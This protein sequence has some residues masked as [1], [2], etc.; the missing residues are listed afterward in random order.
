MKG[1]I[2]VPTFYKA[3]HNNPTGQS[4]RS[5]VLLNGIS[6][7]Y[8]M[9]IEYTNKPTF[10]DVDFALIYA[11]PY[12]NR[13]ELPPGLLECNKR[14]KLISYFEDLQCWDNQECKQNKLKM[15]D[16]YDA[17]MGSYNK[18]FRKWYPQFVDKYIF[19]PDHFAPFERFNILKPNPK[20]IMKCLLSGTIAAKYYPFRKWIFNNVAGNLLTYRKKNI[21]FADY[22]KFLN[23]YFCAIATGSA[24]SVLVAKYFE[25]PAAGTL[26]LAERIKDI[27]LTGLKAGEHY[28]EIN[29]KNVTEKIQHV[30]KNPGKYIEMRDKA[31]KLVR[32]KHS[33]INRIKQFADVLRFVGVES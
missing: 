28:V 5:K 17:L 18:N 23:K 31:T 27:E 19:Y 13:P 1:K 9:P 29:R 32:Q 10:N 8:N 20:P 24:V 7:L 14:V 16:R 11:I 25:I 15:F 4:G 2:I 21:L 33:E 6:K 3:R 22:P 26:L 30:L 12:H